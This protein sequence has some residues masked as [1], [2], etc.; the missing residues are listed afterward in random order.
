MISPEMSIWSESGTTLF[1]YSYE[2]ICNNQFM[3]AFTDYLS[4]AYEAVMTPQEFKTVLFCANELLQN[5]GFYSAEQVMTQENTLSGKGAFSI[6]GNP[7]EIIL[8]AENLTTPEQIAKIAETLNTYNSLNNDDL[9]ALYKQK[10]RE[11]SPE[12]SKGGGIGFIEMIRK[13]KHPILYTERQE[14]Q[15]LFITLTIR[16]QRANNH[17]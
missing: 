6:T 7:S 8:S 10:L 4:G 15:N 17:D 1:T 11:E 13:S 9:K 14:H 16:L 12:D 3:I 2:G 5:I